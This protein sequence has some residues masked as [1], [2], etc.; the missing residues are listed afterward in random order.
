MPVDTSHSTIPPLSHFHTS[1]FSHF[2]CPSRSAAVDA[3]VSPSTRH[4]AAQ[5]PRSC[6]AAICRE[7]S[8]TDIDTPSVAESL[9]S[10]AKLSLAAVP[11]QLRTYPTR[12]QEFL[13]EYRCSLGRRVSDSRGNKTKRC[14]AIVKRNLRNFGQT[15]DTVAEASALVCAPLFVFRL[16]LSQGLV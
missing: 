2:S 11:G 3:E 12:R 1:I 14:K 6:C 4:V 16:R 5:G 8:R 13:V 7:T 9:M 10:A 15:D